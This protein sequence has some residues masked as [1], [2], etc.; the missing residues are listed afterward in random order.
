M[1][2]EWRDDL[3]NIT[4]GKMNMTNYAEAVTE[5]FER[6]KEEMIAFLEELVLAESPSQRPE[7]HVRPLEIM[8]DALAELGYETELHPAEECGGTLVGVPAGYQE[9][10]ATQLLVGHCDTVWPVGTL[11]KM[12]FTVKEKSIHGPGVLD[13]KSG[14]TQMVFAL[15]ALREMGVKPAVA[16]IIIVNSDEEVGSDESTA[17][18]ADWAQKAARAFILE[19]AMGDEGLLKTARKGTGRYKLTIHGKAAHSGL[20]P[21]DGIS[22]VLELSYLTQELFGM[23]DYE[24]GV[25]INVGVIKGGVQPNDT[26]ISE[27]QSS[28]V[29]KS[30][31]GP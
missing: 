21:Q 18:I 29:A 3:Y 16:P 11:E 4:E 20:A 9:G 7:T 15:R 2:I 30:P 22:A 8:A 31:D 12:P 27:N 24:S 6:H 13:M 1:G 28:Q 17:H 23:T 14:L 5:Y 26:E 19:P 10:D 25:T